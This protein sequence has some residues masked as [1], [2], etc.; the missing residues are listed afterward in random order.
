MAKVLVLATNYGSWGEELQ[1]PWD[2][3]NEAGHDVTLATPLGKKPLP[4]VNPI[5]GSHIPSQ[6]WT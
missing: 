4:I 6:K 5:S 3:L 2:A 1:A